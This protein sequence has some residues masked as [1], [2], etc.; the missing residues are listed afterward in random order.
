MK[1]KIKL[2]LIVTSIMIFF[3]TGVSVII[4]SHAARLQTETAMSNTDSLTEKHAVE[5]GRGFDS[6]MDTARMLAQIM[7]TYDAIDV[8]L[9]R[10]LFNKNL[11]SIIATNPSY[12]GIFTVWEP[13]ALDGLDEQFANTPG[14]DHTGQY[15]PW[16][17][18]IS[19]SIELRPYPDYKVLL[20]N[21]SRDEFISNPVWTSVMDEKVLL[22]TVTA[23]VISKTDEL[24]GLVGVTINIKDLQSIVEG[25][26]PYETG[27]AGVFSNDGI[28]AG[29]FDLSKRGKDMRETEDDLLG[30]ELPMV[31]ASM[32]N[33]EEV[34]LQCY[35]P[36]LKSMSYIIYRPIKIGATT[37]PWSIMV[38]IPMDKVLAP[39]HS[40][41]VF[42]T[43]IIIA[44]SVIIAFV[45]FYV[46]HRITKPIVHMSRILKDISDGEGDLTKQLVVNSKDEIGDMAHFF[47]LT[48]EKIKHMVINIKQKTGVLLNVG[49]ELS[50]DMTETTSSVNQITSNIR[51]IKSQVLNQSTSINQANSSLDSIINN[52]NKLN[53][54]IE[55]Q[56]A[57]V[58]QSSSAIEEMLT[59]IKSVTQTLVTNTNNVRALSKA[60]EIGRHSLN[61]AAADIQTI[62]KESA[63]LSEINAVIEDIASQTNLLSVNAAIEA[64]H[65]GEAGKGFAVVADEIRELAESSGS[66][67]KIISTVLQKMK[68][69]I[70]K[71]TKSTDGMLTHFEAISS[72]VRIV[73]EQ[74]ENILNAMEE[75]NAGSQQILEAIARLNDI[76]HKVKDGF[77]E[78][79]QGSKKIRDENE[80][81]GSAA[82]ELSNDIGE[83]ADGADQINITVNRVQTISEENKGNIDTLAQEV[84][85]FKVE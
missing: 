74:E 63:G 28:I 50:T 49:N 32:R 33:G 67:S 36:A 40:L 83:M 75:Q 26:K 6:Y 66:Q 61:E 69:S 3:V 53:E 13:N 51:N 4:L 29:H 60:S 20:D 19:G 58:T 70:D 11:E 48:L 2:C 41:I 39:I 9:R 22:V 30:D 31:V 79:M 44:A 68:D 34:T 21:L 56:A 46:V 55:T 64:A 18:R 12:V 47:N 8:N 23:P 17:T 82:R 15:I 37:T 1:L 71:I 80:N 78:M 43:I 72:G 7:D 62:A 52:I 81:I 57:S 10:L 59:N 27:V 77:Q 5:I 73:S 84:S 14:T 24:I 35:S 76:T 65:A 42:A 45:F 54:F 25:I 38:A 85:L 16:Y